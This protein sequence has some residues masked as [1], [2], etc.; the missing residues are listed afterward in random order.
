MQAPGLDDGAARPAACDLAFGLSGSLP[1]HYREAL[2]AAVLAALP[3]LRDEPG[4]GIH[5]LNVSQGA[6]GQALLSARTRLVLRLPQGQVEA[7]AALAGRSLNLA[8]HALRLGSPQQR[9]LQPW[10]TLYAHLVATQ[11]ADESAF[12]HEVDTALREL[13]VAGRAICGRR[14]AL[15][16]DTLQ[17]YSLMLDGLSAADSLQLMEYGIGGQRLLGC[18]LFVAH[19]SAAAVGAPP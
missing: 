14:Q 8:G 15:E 19:R 11:A 9:E 10:G 12:M 6:G 13:G 3:W 7:A 5:R 4:G 18:G 1:R 2:A 16:G 17:G